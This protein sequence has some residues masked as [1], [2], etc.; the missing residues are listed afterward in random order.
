M[1]KPWSKKRFT[2]AVRKIAYTIPEKK[3]LDITRWN[4]GEAINYATPADPST[5]GALKLST[6]W[7]ML[8]FHNCIQIGTGMTNRIGNKIFLRY[9]Q[10]SLALQGDTDILLNA[11]TCRWVVFHDKANTGTLPAGSDVFGNDPILGTA[12]I[13]SLKNYNNAHRFQ[14]LMDQQHKVQTLIVESAAAAANSGTPVM[15]FYVP[16]FKEITFKTANN[17]LS[18]NNCT[19]DAWCFGITSSVANCCL[20]S[21]SFRCVFNDA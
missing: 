14:I 1:R 12:G 13:G 9:I 8:C 2:R 21:L 4:P 15:H 18:T 5:A 10:F 3:C 11:Q 7:H 16:V 20:A 19:S 17:D 6:A